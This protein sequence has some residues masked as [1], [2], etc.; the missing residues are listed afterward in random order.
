MKRE[1]DVQLMD[2]HAKIFRGG[3]FRYFECGDGWYSLID[4][5]ATQLQARIDATGCEQ[6]VANQF[7]EKFG[8]VRFYFNGGDDECRDIVQKAVALSQVT[9][10][11]CGAPGTMGSQ[12]GWVRVRCAQHVDTRHN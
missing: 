12:G 2:K 11:Y 6:V 7:K 10:D 9:C 8:E 1:L 5:M 4:D 3:R